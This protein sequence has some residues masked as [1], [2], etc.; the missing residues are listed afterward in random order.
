[1]NYKIFNFEEEEGQIVLTGTKFFD[2]HSDVFSTL[3]EWIDL[4]GC[5][6]Q[7]TVDVRRYCNN[8]FWE[9]YQN[10]DRLKAYSNSDDRDAELES[11]WD[12]FGPASERRSKAAVIA[13]QIELALKAELVMRV[14][15][16]WNDGASKGGISDIRFKCDGLSVSAQ[17]ENIPGIVSL[18]CLYSR[19]AKSDT[20]VFLNDGVMT[21]GV[22][23]ESLLQDD[24]IVELVP[25]AKGTGR[26][27]TS[28]FQIQTPFGIG[29][30]V[31]GE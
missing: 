28:I 1:M 16:L 10:L 11:L 13:E 23:Y 30:G 9:A 29:F 15:C 5:V 17:L 31:S 14:C 8:M 21:V 2:L 26:T 20:E 18:C 12:L 6:E 24:G 7:M 22:K 25:S 27:G 4:I 19:L 3:D